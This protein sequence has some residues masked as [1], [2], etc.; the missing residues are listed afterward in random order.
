MFT[1]G[2]RI[3]PEDVPNLVSARVLR[4]LEGGTIH[5]GYYKVDRESVFAVNGAVMNQVVALS[6]G[7]S[8]LDK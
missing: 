4:R 5:P 6:S 8:R 2:D 3:A 7:L 1:S